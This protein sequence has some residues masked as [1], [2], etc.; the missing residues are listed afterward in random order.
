MPAYE[1]NL[2]VEVARGVK[3]F[4][5]LRVGV[6]RGPVPGAGVSARK[7]PGDQNESQL[8]R[9]IENQRQQSEKVRTQGT[10]KEGTSSPKERSS[11]IQEASRT[12]A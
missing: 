7:Q 10:P 6:T 4:M 2:V 12:R 1:N 3:A 11:E 5:N 8:Q 9:Q